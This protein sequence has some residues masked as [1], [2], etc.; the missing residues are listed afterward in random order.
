[1]ETTPLKIEVNKT[2]FAVDGDCVT[3][4]RSDQP[5]L[6]MPLQDIIKFANLAASQNLISVGHDEVPTNGLEKGM[7]LIGRD[8]LV[9]PSVGPADDNSPREAGVLGANLQ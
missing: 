1:M 3:V 2:V 9:L 5:M 7:P 4:C 8:K 6:K